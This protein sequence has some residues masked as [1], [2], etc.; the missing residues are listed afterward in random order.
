M[1]GRSPLETVV[2]FG[3]YISLVGMLSY[4][5]FIECA[6]NQHW[7]EDVRVSQ[8]KRDVC[9]LTSLDNLWLIVISNSNV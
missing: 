7:S 9:P 3:I 1:I 6:T 2:L 4:T 8:N 5:R